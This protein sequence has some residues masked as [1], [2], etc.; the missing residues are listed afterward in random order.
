MDIEEIEKVIAKTF[1]GLAEDGVA[2]TDTMLA[3]EQLQLLLHI[4]HKLEV[5]EK[6]LA[7]HPGMISYSPRVY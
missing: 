7:P 5:L 3:A 1:P 2:P 6:Q 4:Y